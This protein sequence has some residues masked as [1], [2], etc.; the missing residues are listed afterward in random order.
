[1]SEPE[2]IGIGMIGCG[3]VGQGVVKLLSGD[4]AD[5]YTQRL[6]RPLELRR[7]LVRDVSADRGVDLAAG[8]L[9]DDPELFFNDSSLDVIV[10]VAGGLDPVGDYVRRA[11]E[12]KQHVVTANKSLLAARGAEL[13]ALARANDASIA[14][15]ASCGGGI[16][17]LAA[18]KF[19]LAANRI[20]AVYGILNGTCNHI[21]TEMTESGKDYAT[22][23]AEA[24]R[25]GF[26]EADPALDVG[27]A[28]TAQKLAI[29][30]SLAFGV[31]VH[32]QDVTYKGID[33][34]DLEDVAFGSEVGY[35]IK[36]LAVGRRVGNG[37]LL[38]VEPCFLDRREP[39]AHVRGAFNA[40]SVVGHAAGSN[41]FVGHGAGQMPT[42][43]AVVSD[44]INV[45]GG[46]YPHAFGTM[47][48]W[49]DQ[50]EPAEVVDPAEAQSRYYMRVMAIDAPG[51]MAK[52]TAAFSAAGISIASVLQREPGANGANGAP[53]LVPVIITTYETTGGA[54]AE[55]ARAI[56]ELEVVEGVPVRIPI[57]G[58]PKA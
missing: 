28:D 8:V 20:E 48:L 39:M 55:A 45:A 46:W 56:Q 58:L 42:A 32:E 37:L 22:A 27:G 40:L 44:L 12:N 51:V 23:L 50:H 14:F 10:E 6:G 19:G 5:W 2:P 9:T 54:V 36:L 35:R 16:P 47:R 25:L 15:E 34:L 1:V 49:P 18:I 24:Q 30:A 43:S 53:S 26:A 57:V 41:M 31:S 33:T 4:R 29:I 11:L 17:V 7:V 13:F 52:L 21:L 3:T 38:N